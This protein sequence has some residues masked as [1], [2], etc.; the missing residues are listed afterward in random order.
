MPL[1]GILLVRGY[2]WTA[3]LGMG[4][5]TYY[6][7]RPPHGCS[8]HILQYTTRSL[9]VIAQFGSGMGAPTTPCENLGS[10]A[11]PV[12]PPQSYRHLHVHIKTEI[13]C[14]S[15]PF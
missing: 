5:L 11:T 13:Y 7:S 15:L 12:S 2:V 4:T 9:F 14:F 8:T 6:A 3:H 1:C 10:S